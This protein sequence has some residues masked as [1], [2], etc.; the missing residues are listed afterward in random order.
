MTLSIK[1]FTIMTLSITTFNA[2]PVRHH[3]DCLYAECHYVQC[4]CADSNYADCCYA[5]CRSLICHAE[6]RNAEFLKGGALSDD[7][8]LFNCFKNLFENL[9]E[10]WF[11]ITHSASLLLYLAWFLGRR[12]NKKECL[13]LVSKCPRNQ[14]KYESLSLPFSA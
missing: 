2:Y 7:V 9:F 6:C 4:H 8:A 5:E 13:H 11:R 3:V 10:N 1:T 12:D 14:G